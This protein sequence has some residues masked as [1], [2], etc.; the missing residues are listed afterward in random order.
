M[1]T[2]YFQT[3]RQFARSLKN[4]DAMLEKAIAY[5]E[6]RKFEV[7]NFCSARLFPDMLPLLVQVRIACDHA[8]STAAQLS[9]K[10]APVHE[11]NET[12][13]ADLRGRIS[14]CLAYLDT[15]KD[16]DFAATRPDTVVKIAFPPGKTMLA[17][18]YVLSRQVPNFYFH[19]TTAYALLRSGGVE[20]GKGDFLGQINLRD[21]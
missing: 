21:P 3:V 11:D 15:F 5:A 12:T 17:D 14:K 4:L 13:I 16:S 8:K 1:R 10:T 18:D 20:L 19:L 6:K 2:M 9:G 7:N